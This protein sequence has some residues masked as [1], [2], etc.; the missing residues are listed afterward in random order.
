VGFA[1]RARTDPGS[2]DA[3]GHYA[4]STGVD[5]TLEQDV[6]A[7]V[8]LLDRGQLG[9][10]LPM[11]QTHRTAGNFDDW[12][13]GIGDV[14]LNA[15]YD[16]LLAAE[17][18][19]WPGFGVLAAANLPTGSPPDKYEPSHPLAANATGEGTYDVT[20]GVDVEK[21]SGHLYAAVNGWVTHRFARTLAVAGAPLT[22]SFSARWTFLGVASYVFD[23]EAAIGLYVSA[24]GEGPAT[25]N[26]VQDPTTSLRLTTLGAAGV[27]PLRDV[28]RIQGSA[29][30]DVP[31]SSL[32]RNEPAGYGLT[33]SLVRVWL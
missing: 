23:T 5:Q 16:F 18:L 8:R 14:S 9:A 32:G 19:R 27:L 29:F 26:G 31:V 12:G 22:E 30:F 4:A 25:V 11:I 2:F 13:G 1:L 33:A 24:L 6:A 7:S 15:R 10:L 20:L 21:V 3:T 28:W 17:T